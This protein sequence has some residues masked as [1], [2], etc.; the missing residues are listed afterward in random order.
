MEARLEENEEM[1]APLPTNKALTDEGI[2][3]LCVDFLIDGDASTSSCL[4]FTAYLLALNTDVQ[5]KLCRLIENYYQENENATL[6]DAANDIEYIEWVINESLRM[7]PPSA[8]CVCCSLN[9]Y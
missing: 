3:T 7:Y 6:Y 4:S 1:T 9:V 5:D 2:A 8:R